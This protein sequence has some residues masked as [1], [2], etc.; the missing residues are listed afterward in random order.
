MRKIVFAH[1]RAPGDVLMMTCGIRDF[2]GLFP[3]IAVNVETKFGELWD[4]NPHLDRTIKRGDPGV[5]Y[6]RVGYPSIQGSSHGIITFSMAFLLDMIAHADAVEPLGISIGELCSSFQGGRTFGGDSEEEKPPADVEAKVAAWRKRFEKFTSAYYR[7]YGDLHLTDEEK[8]NNL[9]REVYGVD[10]YWVIAPGGKRDC[11]CKIWDWRK[12]QKVVDYF[13]G[14]LKF[15][16]IGRSDHLIDPLRNVISLVDKTPTNLRPLVPLMYHAEGCVSGI[17]FPMH[18][19]AAMPPKP[20]LGREKSRKPCVAIFGGR[21]PWTFAGYSTH[22]ILHNCGV[23]SCSDSGGCWQSRVSPLTKDAEKNN[24]L[25]HAPETVDDRQ[26]PRCMVHITPDDIIRAIERYYE[27]GLYHLDRQPAKRTERPVELR[28]EVEGTQCREISLIASL[29]S[30]GGGEQSALRIAAVL[31]DAGWVVH[32]HPWGKVHENYRAE[33]LQGAYMEG[34][35]P[36]PGIP[37]LFYANDQI[38]DF[39][40]EEVGGR[41]LAGCSD[42]VIGVNYTNGELP[43]CGWI[44]ASGKLRAVIFQNREKADE[45]RRDQIGFDATQV[46]EL[47][48][49]IDLERFYA[50]PQAVRAGNDPLVVLKHCKPDFRKYVTTESCGHGEKKHV[51]QRKFSKDKDVD[52]YQKLLKELPFPVRFEFMEAHQELVDA[53]RDEPRMIFHKWDAM[54]VV[55]F[56]KRGHVYFYRTSNLWRDQYPRCLAEALAAGLPAIS[57]PRDGTKDRI[58]HGDT[59]FYVCDYDQLLLTLKTLH[60]KE[61]LRLEMGTTAKEWAK[62]NLDPRRWVDTLEGALWNTGR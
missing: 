25:C 47:F 37:A 42:L 11:T 48:G 58:Q 60:R 13:D 44:Q 43:R 46:V 40:K 2:K 23:M 8:R 55:D 21:E 54:P 41:L 31:R 10:K 38:Y 50:A 20:G 52:V 4:N 24:R 27:G 7:Q 53:F 26:V 9:V 49:A 5:E 12:F 35:E 36:K 17:S 39:C 29:Q 56:L 34:A 28:P 51:W 19:A 3:D 15:V 62:K 14:A 30:S 33:L 57:E 16:V 59:G 18:L 61:D 32:F 6:Y 1:G 45:W 22:Q